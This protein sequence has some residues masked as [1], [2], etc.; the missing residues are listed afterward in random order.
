MQKLWP[1]RLR[2]RVK[3][4]TEREEQREHMEKD[5][6]FRRPKEKKTKPERRCRDRGTAA[7]APFSLSLARVF[8]DT[9]K[10]V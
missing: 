9:Y 8:L 2:R 10:K 6:N 1:E 4:F 5:L 3:V 7:R